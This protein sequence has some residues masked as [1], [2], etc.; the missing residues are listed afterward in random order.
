MILNYLF[1][2]IFFFIGLITSY[3]DFRRGKIRNKWIILGVV[4]ALSAYLFFFIWNLFGAIGGEI[5][6]YFLWKSLLNG[7]AA[8]CVAYFL[9]RFFESWSA[10][11]AK[12]FFVFSLLIPASYYQ[13]SYLPIFPSFALLVNIFIPLLLFLLFKSCFIFFKVRKLR[14]RRFEILKGLFLDKIYWFTKGTL[15]LGFLG[16]ILIFGF[17]RE[18]NS[19]LKDNAVFLQAIF[20]IVLIISSRFP[21]FK[22]KA[23]IF[24]LIFAF[25]FGW[26]VFFAPRLTFEILAQSAPWLVIF[27][28]TLGL[29]GKL[30]NFYVSGAEKR[31]KGAFPMA[32]WIF[33]G[34]LIT[35]ILKES[36][37]SLAL[38]YIFS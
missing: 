15:I 21:V 28:F 27:L 20:F 13:K 8:L 23:A 22:K 33:L 14:E 7:F 29:F 19:F 34:G 25:S 31:G 30:F 9:W 6:L 10:G 35:L 38:R 16:M 18:T 1:L 2:P 11:D 26:G 17:L 12:L 4:W 24:F 36:V 5:S 32:I 37:L 3:E